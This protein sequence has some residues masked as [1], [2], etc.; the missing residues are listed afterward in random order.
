[1]NPRSCNEPKAHADDEKIASNIRL[2]EPVLGSPN[3][4]KNRAS[5]PIGQF[6]HQ[7]IGLATAAA[8]AF[9]ASR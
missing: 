4:G 5:S 3:A 7:F 2:D 8:S 6:V 9:K 1:M